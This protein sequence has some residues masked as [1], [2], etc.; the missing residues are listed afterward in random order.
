MNNT[1]YK[2]DE[3]LSNHDL[4]KFISKVDKKGV[5]IVDI[6]DIEPN[7]DIE[8][9]YKN[10]GHCVFFVPPNSGGHW[11]C[12]LRNR[13][14]E[15]FF[16]DSFAEHPNYYS[17]N[18]LK[19]FKNNGINKVHINDTILQDETS[20]T[21]GRY[22]IIMTALHKMGIEPTTMVDYFIDGGQKNGSI[23]NFVISLTKKI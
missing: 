22:C 17:K 13:E 7:T 23:D 21:C 16:I 19:C 12:T 1:N 5:N 14:N 15:I 11:I 6:T 3:P 9:I 18:I 4:N 20:Q 8:E 2:N 10:R